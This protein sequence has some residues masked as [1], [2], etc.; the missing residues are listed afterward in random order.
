MHLSFELFEKVMAN[1]V[2]DG[3]RMTLIAAEIPENR[4]VPEHSHP[5]KQFGTLLEGEAEFGSEHNIH[6]AKE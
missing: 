3:E 4:A 2:P 6:T 5:H 1:V